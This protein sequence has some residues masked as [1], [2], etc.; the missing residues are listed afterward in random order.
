MGLR[1]Q[2]HRPSGHDF[3]QTL[4]DSVGRRSLVCC[5]PRGQSQTQLSNLATNYTA[6]KDKRPGL[7]RHVNAL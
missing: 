5:S 4:G 7:G 1:R 3:E 6:T 2:Y